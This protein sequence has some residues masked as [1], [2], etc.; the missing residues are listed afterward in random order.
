M[1]IRVGLTG[2]IGSGKSTVAGMFADR[3]AVVI[4]ADIIAREVVRPG[5]PALQ[6]ITETFGPGVVSDTGEL[7]RAALASIVFTDEK[8]LAQLNAITHPRIA[9]RTQEL[10]AA[11]DPDAVVVYDMPLLVENDLTE[12]WDWV[13]V[14]EAPLSQRIDRLRERGVGA[15]NMEQRMAAQASDAQRR[16]VADVVIV[17]DGDLSDLSARVDVAWRQVARGQDAV[18]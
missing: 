1:T 5:Q 13:V 16:A 3:G 11:A 8:A 17:N 12:G 10:M 14:V 2:G 6:E 18:T 9:A 4:D 7:D 15:D